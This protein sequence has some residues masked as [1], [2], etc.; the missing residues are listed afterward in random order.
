MDGNLVDTIHKIA[1]SLKIAV[2]TGGNGLKLISILKVICSYK[3][4]V[5]TSQ[6]LFNYLADL[7]AIFS[8]LINFF[9][10]DFLQSENFSSL[11]HEKRLQTL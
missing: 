10:E 9:Y 7:E 8:L 4:T 5:F 3:T 1:S 6:F 11:L 2:H